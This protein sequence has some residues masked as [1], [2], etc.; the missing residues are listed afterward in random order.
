MVQNSPVISI[1]IPVYNTEPYLRKCI[2]SILKQT[3]IDLECLLIDDG[4]SDKSPEICDEYAGKD[5]RV[6]VVHQ[7]NAG[8]SAARNTGIQA[9]RG[10]YIAFVDSDDYVLQGMYYSLLNEMVHEEKD[11]SCCGYVHNG[12]EYV[13]SFNL[14]NISTA[15]IV[16]HLEN[17]LLFGLVWNKIYNLEIINNH[18]VRFIAGCSFGEDMI[19]N[20]QYFSKINSICCI[21][22]ALYFYND[23]TDSITKF[24]PTHSQCLTRF[25]NVSSNII[26]LQENTSENFIN[27]LLALDFQKVILLMQSLYYPRQMSY[28]ERSKMIKSIKQFFVHHPALGTFKKN[29][30]FIL[31]NILMHFP[32]YLFDKAAIILFCF[33]RKMYIWCRK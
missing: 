31:Y 12:K 27:R 17:R 6:I 18:S 28:Y 14:D 29:I 7:K 19:F 30:Y 26:Q 23:N 5:N 32:I 4:S 16:Y 22:R 24:K 9:A 11:T 21:N 2:D 8:V 3:F 25:L 1:I 15:G 13:P 10:K 20:L 33:F